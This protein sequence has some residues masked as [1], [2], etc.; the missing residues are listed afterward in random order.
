MQLGPAGYDLVTPR[1]RAYN[2]RIG[3]TKQRM[4]SDHFGSHELYLL[5]GTLATGGK[6][7]DYTRKRG[8]YVTHTGLTSRAW[9]PYICSPR[10]GRKTVAPRVSVG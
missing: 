2:A 5:D 9:S 8:T 10:S 7:F 3:S 6:A 1:P 4:R